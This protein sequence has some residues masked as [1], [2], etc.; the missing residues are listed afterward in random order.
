MEQRGGGAWLG[1]GEGP[2]HPCGTAIPHAI[3][4]ALGS[5][6][7]M[8]LSIIIFTNSAAIEPGSSAIIIMLS[9]LLIILIISINYKQEW[10]T[11]GRSREAGTPL[12]GHEGLRLVSLPLRPLPPPPVSG[13][14]QV[15]SPEPGP[16][17]LG[18]LGG[19]FLPGS[20]KVPA[21]SD[22]ASL[23]LPDT[24]KAQLFQRVVPN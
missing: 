16:G 23:R 9:L 5:S 3:S 1:A 12:G 10:G 14:G 19:L 22:R 20:R 21:T 15:S 7:L 24:T 8:L 4:H 11:A 6:D 17:V 13:Q 18:A 2:C